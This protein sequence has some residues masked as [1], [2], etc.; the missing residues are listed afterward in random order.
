MA[1]VGGWKR[2]SINESKNQACGFVVMIAVVSPLI[3]GDL[4][5]LTLQCFT[6]SLA[7]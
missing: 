1:G 7:F 2:D 4:V 6:Q 5:D 3:V